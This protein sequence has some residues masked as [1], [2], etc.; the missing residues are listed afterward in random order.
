MRVA[1][2]GGEARGSPGGA[3]PW[4]ESGIPA[5]VEDRL[6]AC[7]K[8]M[9]SC[10]KHGL[11]QDRLLFDPLVMAGEHRPEPGVWSPCTRCGP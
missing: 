1:P 3:W 9:E 11:A 2:P 6:E 10:A 4:G 5:T 7:A 8:I